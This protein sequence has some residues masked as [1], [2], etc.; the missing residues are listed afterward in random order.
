MAKNTQT[1]SDEQIITALMT[2][3]T[4]QKAAEMCGISPRTLY[5]RMNARSFQELHRAVKADILRKAVYELNSR[6]TEA[7]NTISEIML[8]KEA[9]SSDRL[10]AAGMIL[11][12]AGKFADRLN[13]CEAEN[14][15][16]YNR[17][18][19]DFSSLSAVLNGYDE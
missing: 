9:S 7:V 3:G 4:A 17:C 10:K 2:A 8:D 18:D 19:I 16:E 5:S 13:K 11:D 14:L 12:N 1:V 6:M 15:E